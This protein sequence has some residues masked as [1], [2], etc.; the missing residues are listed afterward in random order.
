MTIYTSDEG[1]RLLARHYTALLERWPVPAER[2][3]VPT[4]QGSTFVLACG[5][6]DAAPLVLLHGSGANAAMWADDVALW[7]RHF[8]VYAVDVIGE[9]G[10]SA[11]VRP[12][13]H[14]DAHA[15][16]LDDV[17][18]ALRVERAAF[19][20]TSLGGLLALDYAIRR[21]QRV[22]RLALRCPCG[23][24]RQKWGVL[25]AAPF[26]LPFGEWGRRTMLK[27]ALGPTPTPARPT[28]EERTF[29]AYVLLIHR[30]FRPRREKLP[31]V[32]DADLAGLDMPVQVTIGGRDRL[33]D[34]HDTRRRLQRA[35]PRVS[36]TFLPEVGHLLRDQTRPA[37]DFLLAEEGGPPRA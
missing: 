34:S 25:V 15:L 10:L 4:R 2:L 7:A 22:E 26:V 12:A 30:H 3:H 24:G 13:L 23:I 9:P 27:L 32:T 18:D 36:V 29:G 11:P 20:G 8:R 17:L 19:V 21:P 31:V 33:I 35:A 37:L 1:A 14:S 5:P 28:A 6:E 16:W